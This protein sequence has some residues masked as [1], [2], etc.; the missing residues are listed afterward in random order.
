[1]FNDIS[2]IN[3]NLSFHGCRHTVAVVDAQLLCIIKCDSCMHFMPCIPTGLSHAS[4]SAHTPAAC[5]SAWLMVFVLATEQVTDTI[6]V[7]IWW[8]CDEVRKAKRLTLSVPIFMW[9]LCESLGTCMH[10]SKCINQTNHV[11][12]E[13]FISAKYLSLQRVNNTHTHT[14]IY[15]ICVCM[16]V[17][18]TYIYIVYMW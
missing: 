2:K 9:L 10:L 8:F 6:A 1:M 17:I 4:T 15:I 13:C 7:S 12:R 3:F 5:R 18:Y 11:K 16:C 14:H